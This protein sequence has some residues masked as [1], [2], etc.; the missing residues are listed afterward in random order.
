MSF[1][2]VALGGALGA[3]LRYAISL[4]PVKTDFPVLTLITNVVGAVAIGF[5]VGLVSEKENVSPNTVL[6]WKTGVCGGFTTF[7]TFSL[8]AI[9]LFESK[10][11]FLG[12]IYIVLSVA[13]CLLG[14]F[15]GKKLA[16]LI[17]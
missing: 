5:I 11:Y 10:M 7:S 6:F 4:I 9:T 12:G 8:E 1:I 14:I 3:V 16:T 17:A 13:F 2:F 15:C